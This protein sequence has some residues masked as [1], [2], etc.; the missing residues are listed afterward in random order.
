MKYAIAAAIFLGCVSQIQAQTNLTVTVHQVT[1][2]VPK[3]FDKS[4]TE[5]DDRDNWDFATE[6][7]SEEPAIKCRFAK[8]VINRGVDQKDAGHSC[9]ASWNRF[10]NKYNGKQFGIFFCEIK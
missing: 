7:L 10:Y 5:V 6:H 4:A 2:Q 1:C 3:G 9:G 8:S